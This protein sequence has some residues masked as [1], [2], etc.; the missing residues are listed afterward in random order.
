MSE[1]TNVAAPATA[2]DIMRQPR[3]PETAA[4][5]CSRMD[6]NIVE[7]AYI[8]QGSSPAIAISAQCS[9]GV[10]PAYF[11]GVPHSRAARA[12]MAARSRDCGPVMSCPPFVSATRPA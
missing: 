4:Q 2:A 1:Q 8:H 7:Y 10:M 3:R 11:S 12:A 9:A 5:R 6:A